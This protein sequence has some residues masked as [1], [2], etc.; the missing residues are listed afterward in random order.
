MIVVAIKAGLGNQL[1]QYACGRAL[2]LR[3]GEPIKF[4]I[5]SYARTV[6]SDT[7]RQYLLDRFNIA[8]VAFAGEDE[9]RRLKYPHGG[10]SMLYRRLRTKLGLH[11]VGWV[12]RILRARGDI[13]LDGYW[14]TEKYFADRAD[15]IRA[16]LSLKGPLSPAA[17]AVADDI[18]AGSMPAVSLHVRRGDVAR[19]WKT[20][21]YAGICTPAYYEA[22]LARMKDELAKRGISSFRAFVFSDGMEWAK[23]NIRIPFPTVYVPDEAPDYEQLILMSRCAHHIIA[24]SSFSWWGA[25]LDP[26]PDKIVIAPKRWI[27]KH[28]YR[29]RDTVP[30]SWIRI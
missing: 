13:Y 27:Q 26:K 23:E 17:Q 28:G 4:D 10:L 22:A 3:N 30:E 6:N 2:S 1:F 29:H 21:P 5:T 24:N 18:G 16:E 25:W 14:Q 19:D 15:V 9:V 12:P 20:N 11:N 8:D 7:P